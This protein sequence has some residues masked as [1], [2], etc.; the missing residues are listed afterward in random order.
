MIKSHQIYLW[1][2]FLVPVLLTTEAKAQ[3]SFEILRTVSLSDLQNDYKSLFLPEIWRFTV[4][5]SKD[6]SSPDIDDWDWIN[7][8]TSLEPS[9]LDILD[10]NGQG[11]FRLGLDVDSSLVG[12]PLSVD[13]I[14]NSGLAQFYLNGQKLFEISP[15]SQNNI[16]ANN[17][18]VATFSFK[19][20]GRNILAIRFQNNNADWYRERNLPSGIRFNF[21][22]AGFYSTQVIDFIRQLSRSHFFFSGTLF[23]FSLLHLLL[24]IYQRRHR[25]NLFF[26]L[27]TLLFGFFLIVLLQ[28]ELSSYLTAQYYLTHI[29]EVLRGLTIFFFMLFVY[30]LLHPKVSLVRVGFVAVLVA[31]YILYATL[32]G[33]YLLLVRDVLLI[34]LAVETLYQLITAIYFKRKGA[35]IFGVGLGV[36]VASQILIIFINFD[37]LV[38]SREIS[39]VFGMAFLLLAMSVSLSR[40]F[41]MTTKRLETNLI[42]IQRLSNE[43]LEKERKLKK[44]E[45]ERQLL[46]ADNKRKTDELEEARKLQLSLLPKKLP[47]IAGYDIS[48]EMLPATEVGG[49]YYD[50]HLIGDQAIFA[51]GDATGHGLKAGIIVAT[52]KSFFHTHAD[53]G[54]NLSLL[55]SIS[56]AV[57][58]MDARMM[59][60]SMAVIRFDKGR[61]Q[62]T[63]AGMPPMVYYNKKS[64]SAKLI[65]LKGM[66][67]GS[68]LNFPYQ[69]NELEMS[70]GDVLIAL[71]DG[72]PEL[73]D[74]EKKMYDI[75]RVQAV[76]SQYAHETSDQIRYRLLNDARKWTKGAPNQ[77]DITLLIIKKEK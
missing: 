30:E 63:A 28:L 22:E 32:N 62:L 34:L 46:E 31:A 60:M 70:K 9:A 14:S 59:Y 19:E 55:H 43:A 16:F 6:L 37:V 75:S 8:S 24:F 56:T 44:E 29:V 68:V 47:E 77:D 61:L 1:L 26:A 50:Y 25:E 73:F 40:N 64:N 18:H 45:L 41:A 15:S 49:D 57:K 53:Q 58:N 48:A 2:L 20:P 74:H 11:W 3:F 65:T 35:V 72:L 4:D 42:E 5:D 52:V 10:W 54:D 39:A 17:S 7:M 66:P 21:V 51:I 33:Q 76:I 69:T 71:S 27:F 12:I 36:F 67:L 38:F 13:V 23:V